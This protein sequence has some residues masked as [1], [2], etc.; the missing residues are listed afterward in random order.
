MRDISNLIINPFFNTFK[1]LKNVL[2]IKY[3]IKVLQSQN[4]DNYK[5]SNFQHLIQKQKL[6][7]D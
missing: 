1:C 2:S 6:I 4:N 7:Y 3:F 5:S